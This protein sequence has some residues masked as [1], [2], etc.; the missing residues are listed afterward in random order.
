MTPSLSGRTATILAGVRPTM[1]LASA[2]TASGRLVLAS[3]AT[4]E[5]SLMT[6]PLPRTS[7]RVLAVPRSMPMSREN[8]P[9]TLLKGLPMGISAPRTGR[10]GKPALLQTDVA[11]GAAADHDVVEDLDV[12]QLAGA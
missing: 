9:M 7:T 2:P 10:E 4:T 12:E 8:M 11:V 3:M 5:G 1:R 6:M